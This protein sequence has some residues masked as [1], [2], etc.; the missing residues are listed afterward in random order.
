MLWI[1]EGMFICSA[2]GNLELYHGS[3]VAAVATVMAGS[4]LVLTKVA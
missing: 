1:V 3:E 4:S 2:D